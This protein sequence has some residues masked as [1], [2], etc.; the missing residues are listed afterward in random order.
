MLNDNKCLQLNIIKANAAIRFIRY[1]F[2][3]VFS[4]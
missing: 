2:A 1:Y 4:D 3:F